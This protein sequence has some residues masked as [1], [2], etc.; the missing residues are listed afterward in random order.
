MT[1]EDRTNLATAYMFAWNSVKGRP[2]KVTVDAHGWFTVSH[3][4]YS[5]P[6]RR[7]ASELLKGLATLTMRISKREAHIFQQNQTESV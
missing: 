7:R 2:C 1:N 5:L 6:D 4:G 3:Q